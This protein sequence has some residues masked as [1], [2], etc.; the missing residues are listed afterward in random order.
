MG[1]GSGLFPFT[2]KVLFELCFCLWEGAGFDS[3]CTFSIDRG[4]SKPGVLFCHHHQQNFG[5]GIGLYIDCFV[6]FL[7]GEASVIVIHILNLKAWFPTAASLVFA[8]F[9]LLLALE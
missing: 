1:C 9:A 5:F 4:D 3:N 2:V 8:A 7:P 6:G